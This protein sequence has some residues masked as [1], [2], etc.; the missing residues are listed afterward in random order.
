MGFNSG[1]KGLNTT[2][3]VSGILTPIIWNC[4]HCRSSLWFTVGAW[5]LQ[6]C[7][8]AGR[9]DHNQK[10]CYHQALTV[11]Q[12]LLLQ[13]LQLL[14]MGMRMPKHVELYL[15]DKLVDSVESMMMH[16]LANPKWSKTTWEPLDTVCHLYEILQKAKCFQIWH[17]YKLFF[18]C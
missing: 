18:Y 14:M 17:V 7:W 2:Q 15:K 8:P 10:H 16:G 1:F 13:L 11:N 9:P 6:C 3:H 5:G 4:N 12:R